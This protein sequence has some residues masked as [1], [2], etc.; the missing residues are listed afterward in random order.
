[1]NQFGGGW[2]KQ[3]I[4]IVVA[5]AKAYLTIMNKCPQ[6]KCLYF[7]GFAGSG[8]IYREDKTDIEVIK[9]AAKRI[10]D[11]D[12]PK[13]FDMYYFVE[14]DEVNKEELDRAID[15]EFPNKPDFILT[16]K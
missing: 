6:F 15:K 10:L 11:I 4:E 12:F 8:G 9:G 5:Y 14:L 1:M 13:S 2:T 16:K 7:D 3:K